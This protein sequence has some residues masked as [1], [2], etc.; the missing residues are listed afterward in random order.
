M[1]RHATHND[2]LAALSHGAFRHHHVVGD[3]DGGH[4]NVRVGEVPTQATQ[5]EHTHR[6]FSYEALDNKET[7]HIKPSV[8]HW[9][10]RTRCI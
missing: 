7:L 5:V 1:L 6:Y 9:I 2:N 8:K 3:E 10:I 4:T